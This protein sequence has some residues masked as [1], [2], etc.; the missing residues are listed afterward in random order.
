MADHTLAHHLA[1]RDDNFLW[2]RIVAAI[3]VIYGH[4]FALTAPTVPATFFCA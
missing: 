3:A 2:L 1:R 4:S